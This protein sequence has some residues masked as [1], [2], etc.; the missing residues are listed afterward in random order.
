MPSVGRRLSASAATAAPTV[1]F[2]PA[3]PM[4]RSTAAATDCPGEAIPGAASAATG[5]SSTATPAINL[6]PKGELA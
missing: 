3:M 5:R 2:G 1:R 4:C 6:V